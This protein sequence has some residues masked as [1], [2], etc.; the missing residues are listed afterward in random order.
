MAKPADIVSY[1]KSWALSNGASMW[2]N[3]TAISVDV[4]NAKQSE[5]CDKILGD[6]SSPTTYQCYAEV[7]CPGTTGDTSS[8]SQTPAGGSVT[9]PNEIEGSKRCVQN[10]P[11]FYMNTLKENAGIKCYVQ[12][13]V[14]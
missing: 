12:A 6:G 4:L 9:A 5:K 14:N 2:G 10:Y 11:G 3:H 8:I 13:T 7:L 1:C